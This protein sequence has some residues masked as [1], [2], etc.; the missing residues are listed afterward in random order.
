MNYKIKSPIFL[1]LTLLL[2]GISQ[3]WVSNV[4]ASDW[5]YTVRPGDSIWSICSRYAHYDNCW[6]ELASY[7]GLAN[8]ALVS[9]GKV[10]KVPNEWLKTTPLAAVVIHVNGEVTG[11][12]EGSSLV[13]LS[14]GQKLN[15]GSSITVGAGTVTIQFGDGST[16]VMGAQ[17]ELVI[18]SV[19]AFK[20]DKA[21]SIE[22]HLPRG[23]AKISVPKREPRTRFRVRTPAAVAAV[24]G[25]ELRVHSEVDSGAMRSEV[26]QGLVA[27]EAAGDTVDLPAGF[28][29]KAELGEKLAQPTQLL[30]APKWDLS[31]S[32]P[33]YV[34][35]ERNEQAKN[36]QLVLMEDDPNIDKVITSVVISE[37]NYTF[38]GLENQCYQIAVNAADNIGFNGLESRRQYCNQS[39]PAKPLVAK[40]QMRGGILKAN[41]GSVDNAAKYIVQV[42][43]NKQFVDVLVLES[44]ETLNF[45]SSLE[46]NDPVYLRVKAVTDEGVESD[47]SEPIKVQP[48]RFGQAVIGVLATIAMFAIL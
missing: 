44:M 29:L 26:L 22:V 10:I 7:N 3:A 42:S 46:K 9:T 5:S 35:W 19:S 36:Y 40:A 41:W 16:L 18:N 21:H 30:L 28:G 45:A 27:I 1:S 15:V 34:A 17:S 2:I 47:Y 38:E 32:D 14:Q 11:T 24:R 31:C 4:H 20:Q 6:R 12:I 43:A 13:E 48:R 39:K 37:N 23:D 8:P 33:G 25:T